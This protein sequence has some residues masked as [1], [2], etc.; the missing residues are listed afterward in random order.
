MVQKT[1]FVQK[2]HRILEDESHANLIRWSPCGTSF[3]VIDCPGFAQKVLPRV[4]K[5]NNYTSF[6]RQLNLYGFHKK[7]RSYHRQHPSLTAAGLIPTGEQEPREF[8]HPKFIRFRPDLVEEIRR[9]PST[10]AQHQMVQL[11][12]LQRSQRE[13]LEAEAALRERNDDTTAGAPATVPERDKM[14]RSPSSSSSLMTVDHE[15]HHR[16]PSM[17]VAN[18]AHNHQQQLPTRRTSSASGMEFEYTRPASHVSS[19]NMQPTQHDRR[20][21]HHGDAERASPTHSTHTLHQQQQDHPRSPFPSCKAL[22][23]ETTS[24]PPRPTHSRPHPA[25]PA[26]QPF[27]PPPTQLHSPSIS[28]PTAP[29]TASSDL[30]R[31]LA[32][33]EATVRTLVHDIR[34]AKRTGEK[35]RTDVEYLLNRERESRVH[36]SS[37]EYP[38]RD[39]VD[40]HPRRLSST[41]H[42]KN[43]T[44]MSPPPTA[45]STS[46]STY[47][48]VSQAASKIRLPPPAVLV[49]TPRQ[50]ALY[51]FLMYKLLFFGYVCVQ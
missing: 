50:R 26:P 30:L 43:N 15:Q 37:S 17:S 1:T 25:P 7:N 34:D 31:H 38:Y 46:S 11:R 10:L 8:S 28:P 24:H 49:D 23:A 27:F 5:H 14:S 18:L 48:P 22:I 45:S 36:T 2:L 4:F 35:L 32:S 33:L 13:R 21:H 42:H 47:P 19:P 44:T 6:V 51:L 9:K 41:S 20:R 16:P 3:L 12:E 40:T 29:H 39:P